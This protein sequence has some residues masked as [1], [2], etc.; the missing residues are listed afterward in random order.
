MPAKAA[1]APK[2]AF[3]GGGIAGL[4][5]ALLYSD[6]HP[7]HTVTVYEA[8]GRWGGNIETYYDPKKAY[9]YEA[10][11]GRFNNHHKLLNGLIE[12]FGLTP[13]PITSKKQSCELLKVP[14]P[15][16]A[17]KP[18]AAVATGAETMTY[19]EYL[20]QQTSK[21]YRREA[22][23]AFGYD[24]EFDWMNAADA[25]RMFRMDF[26]SSIQYFAL[27]EGL[28]ELVKRMVKTLD[29]RPN[30]HLRLRRKLTG[31]H[32]DA[33]AREFVVNVGKTH[34]VDVLYL[35]LPKEALLGIVGSP[36]D[37]L[38][39]A[40]N[41]VQSVPLHRIYGRFTKDSAYPEQRTTT[42]LPIRQ[43]IPIQPALKLSMVSYSDTGAADDWHGLYKKNR[44]VFKATLED[45]LT[46]MFRVCDDRRETDRRENERADR[47]YRLRWARSYYWAAGVH[48]WKAGV[49]SEA[50]A[51]VVRRPLGAE[52][53]CFI[54][55]EAYSRHQG[56]IEGA[57]MTVQE[58]FGMKNNLKK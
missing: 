43:Y 20:E 57:L 49:S 28:S 39:E 56:W 19:G 35:A 18:K 38:R 2:A 17:P 46:R 9:Q 12:R 47:T 52:V 10:G 22:Q 27:K 54:V 13:I 34:R 45:T 3:I 8:S 14:K 23:E 6:A 37:H 26:R 1:L 55:G 4:Y 11:A 58:T 36:I 7:G 30:V 15:A 33:A 40:L 44:E 24:A 32:W 42:R 16:L 31:W 5:A 53:P 48:V 29:E 21:E 51:R 41:A 25:L 50:V